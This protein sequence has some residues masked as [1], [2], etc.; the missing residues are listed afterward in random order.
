MFT[1]QKKYII[2]TILLLITE[3]LIALYV[4]DKIIRPYIG[5]FLVVILIYCFIRSF[6]K[7]KIL[8]VALEV[9]LF[10]Y[11]VEILQYFNFVEIIGLQNSMVAVIIIGNSFAWADI[12]AYSMG[13]ICVIM[14]E[15]I[16][17]LKR[18][19]ICKKFQ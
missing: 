4:H 6:F 13:I 18:K 14:L 9:L 19:N 12:I 2:L 1:F 5:D 15:K 10:A 11:L 3:I 17:Y 8:N 7:F 16:K